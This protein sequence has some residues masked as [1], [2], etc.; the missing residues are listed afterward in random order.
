MA[1]PAST[2]IIDGRSVAPR[3]ADEPR[4]GAAGAARR[5]RDATRR[6]PAAVRRAP[7]PELLSDGTIDDG[8]DPFGEAPTPVLPTPIESDPETTRAL[9]RSAS[10]LQRIEGA[11]WRTWL[12]D[13][14]QLATAAGPPEALEAL[15]RVYTLRCGGA[16][17]VTAGIVVGDELVA[18]SVTAVESP[19]RR[20]RITPATGAPDR[21]P[22]MIQYLDVDDDVAIVRVPGLR[23]RPIGA[24]VE[25]GVQPARALA[26]GI[27]AGSGGR[28]PRRMPVYASMAEDV[29]DVEQHDGLEQR[30]S[31]R[32]VLPMI[33][34]VDD[35]FTGGM[36]IATNDARGSSGWGLHGMIRARV[37][38]RSTGGG[39][40]VPARIIQQAVRAASARDPWFEHRPGGCPQWR[41]PR[42]R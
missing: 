3:A 26:L 33:G 13:R 15:V 34:G 17:T 2:L 9:A 29:I 1:A 4:I 20:I 25:R 30:I 6:A 12:D 39:I 11:Q 31:D 23:L 7:R 14:S 32:A 40:A 36:L 24:H 35:G 41:R 16:R 18:T 8:P 42:S 19:Q 37:P 38:Y 28:G 5:P 22:G 21:I 10:D 27:D